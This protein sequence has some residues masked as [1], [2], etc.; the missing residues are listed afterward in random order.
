MGKTALN[1][2]KSNEVKSILKL[3]VD[4]STSVPTWTNEAVIEWVAMNE[5]ENVDGIE[6]ILKC[7]G[8]LLLDM[9][10]A[11]DNCKLT[12]HVR[13]RILGMI[14]DAQNQR[15]NTVNTDTSANEAEVHE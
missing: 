8:E 15:M 9:L 13:T 5:L 2:A 10:Y 12:P 14:H 11:V 3:P 6:F 1:L 4:M 7:N